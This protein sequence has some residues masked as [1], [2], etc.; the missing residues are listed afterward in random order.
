[1]RGYGCGCLVKVLVLVFL[2]CGA[3][4]GT[5]WMLFRLLDEPEVPF[6]PLQLADGRRAQQK[7]FDV[8]GHSA[9]TGTSSVVRVVVISEP[10]L[11]AFLAF[12]LA[13]N[14]GLPISD[15]ATRLVGGNVVELVGQA[16]LYEILG[17]PPVSVVLNF[18]PQRWA[19]RKVWIWIR[20]G[21]R[22]ESKE[23]ILDV[24]D[25]ALGRQ[26]LPAPLARVMLD[27]AT[28]RIVRWPVPET[29]TS[30]VIEPGKL[31]IRTAP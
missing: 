15:M 1:M 7:L 22:M 18:L 13:T 2:L 9:K 29:V 30:V 25:F 31:I 20:A 6:T 10:E 12:H 24:H 17:R 27:P 23:L 3:T 19:R 28:H 16:P 14:R 26:R 5:A 21:V 4:I 8:I 11:N